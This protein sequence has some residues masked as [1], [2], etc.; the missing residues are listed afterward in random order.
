MLA[1]AGIGPVVGRADEAAAAVIV[2]AT[3]DGSTDLGAVTASADACLAGAAATCGVG[4]FV[5]TLAMVGHATIVGPAALAGRP[6]IAGPAV[7][8]AFVPT[9]VPVAVLGTGAEVGALD[10]P[11]FR[12]TFLS[13]TD[14]SGTVRDFRIAAL[15]RS[16]E[17]GFSSR[18]CTS[19]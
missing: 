16:A 13:K 3:F 11:K 4:D 2:A 1:G 19:T 18:K 15:P 14:S 7:A 17:T 12:V 8:A 6:T 9:V 5:G 10:T